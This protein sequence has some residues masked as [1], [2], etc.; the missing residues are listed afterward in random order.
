MSS[1]NVQ[2]ACRVAGIA[3]LCLVM[4]L[5]TDTGGCSVI[6]PTPGF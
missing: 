6:R 2:V 5:R 1:A 3:N 4:I